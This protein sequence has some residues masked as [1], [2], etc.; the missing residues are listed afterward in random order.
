MEEVQLIGFWP[1]PYVYRVIWALKLK[2][3]KYEY[4]EEDIFN[5]TELLLKNNP[6]HKTVPVL[7]HGGK[8]IP[9]STVI[10]E[11]LEDKWPQNPL[12][13]D[14]P[15]KRAVARFWT[16]FGEDKVILLLI[17]QISLHKITTIT[18]FL[19][20]CFWATNNESMI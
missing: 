16:K 10:L 9:E 1:S 19:L 12:L 17:I 20:Y 13:P 7:L 4:L 15:H 3:I 8:P 6:V 18:S 11:Y 5:K 2:G 14:D